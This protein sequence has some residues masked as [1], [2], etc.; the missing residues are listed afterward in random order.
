[1]KT[2]EFINWLALKRSKETIRSRISN[3]LKVEKHEGDLD[4]H[5]E[6][7]YGKYL[8]ER[9]TYSK[10]DERDGLPKKHNIPIDGVLIT[11]TSTFKNSAKLYMD[12]RLFSDNDIEK[13]ENS[14]KEIECINVLS[15]DDKKTLIKYRLR[16]S[17]FRKQLINY[18]KGN[19]SVS[20]IN[21]TEILIASHIKPY[22]ECNKDEK[23]DVY[24]GLL[25]T[26]N[27]DK[28]FDKFLITFNNRGKIIIS[29][30]LSDKELEILNISKSDKIVIIKEHKKYLNFHKKRFEELNIEK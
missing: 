27:Y 4:L 26:P 28:L 25:L 19:C 20:N 15:L 1:M 5:F 6:K 7:D 24:N 11:G 21:K 29:D 17:F 9:L 22:S 8:L 16:Q 2:D 12:F 23:Y 3:A 30:S 14:I 10:K 13:I 18:W